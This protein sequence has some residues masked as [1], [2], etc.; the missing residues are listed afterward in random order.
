MKLIERSSQ[1]LTLQN[2]NRPKIARAF[3]ILCLLAGVLLLT[4][5]FLKLLHLYTAQLPQPIVAYVA[6]ALMALGAWT[7]ITVTTTRVSFD[8]HHSRLQIVWHRFLKDVKYTC[9]LHE[10]VDVK[11]EKLVKSYKM[12]PILKITTILITKYYLKNM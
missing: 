3:G 6:A 2:R 7:I 9:N 8:R 11:L 1:R 12:P 10:I 5:P 4:Q